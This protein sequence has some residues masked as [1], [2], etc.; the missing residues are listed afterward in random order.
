MKICALK[1]N[2]EKAVLKVKDLPSVI[3]QH[4]I[5]HLDGILFIDKADTYTR[6]PGM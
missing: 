1:R 4:E 5:D 6:H 3:F 2:G